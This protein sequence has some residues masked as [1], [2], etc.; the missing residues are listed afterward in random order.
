MW[1]RLFVFVVLFTCLCCVVYMFVFV[2]LFTCLFVL[3]LSLSLST[4]D[5]D[6]YCSITFIGPYY[7]D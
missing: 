7:I 4:E 5:M 6:V 1:T 2:V 3:C